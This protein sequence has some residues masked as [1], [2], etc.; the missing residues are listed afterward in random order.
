MQTYQVSTSGGQGP[1]ISIVQKPSPPAP[2]AVH[3]EDHIL[4]NT[5]SLPIPDWS[6]Q[7]KRNRQYPST[8][9]IHILKKVWNAASLLEGITIQLGDKRHT[10]WRIKWMLQEVVIQSNRQIGWTNWQWVG[11]TVSFT[12]HLWNSSSCAA[13]LTYILSFN[14]IKALEFLSSLNNA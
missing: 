4:K 9:R 3:E 14:L 5:A 12:E 13:H 7:I 6:E 10:L 11:I 2:S 8:C 1:G